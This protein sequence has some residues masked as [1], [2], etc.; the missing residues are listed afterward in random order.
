M[1][2]SV[3]L[4]QLLGITQPI[5]QAPM[6]GVS[7]PALASAVSAAGGLG[8]LGLGASS[9]SAAETAIRQV[10]ALTD[11]PFN[12]NLFCHR[13]ARADA[14]REA[15]WLAALAPHFAL[16]GST[17]PARLQSPYTSFLDDAA[18]LDVLIEA[19]VPVVSFHFG[20]PSSDAIAALKSAGSVTMAC[21]T[22]ADEARSI[23]AAGIDIVVAQGIEAGGHRGVF[24]ADHDLELGTLALV[25]QVV[26]AVSVPVVAAGGIMD[27]AGIAAA[28]SLGAEG[29]Q[30]GTAFV[31]CDESGASDAYR[32]A[33]LSEAARLTRVIRTISG[34]PARGIVNRM[35]T[36]LPPADLAPDYPIAYD[37]AKALSAAATAAGDD[38]FGVFWAGQGAPLAR[39]MPAATLMETL[40]REW[41]EARGRICMP[42]ETRAP[43]PNV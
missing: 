22:T 36:D 33:L 25:R 38:A 20:L 42:E 9:A 10:R 31:A 30:L 19:R 43:R 3:R 35:H 18:M 17:A 14:A 4:T 1:Q 21:A 15:A 6:A 16:Y 24:D 5:I 40:L 8:S 27:G 37:A 39:A 23:E 11:R 2:A 7:T 12:V 41:Q 29:V 26:R 34:R 13:R 28:L 32:A